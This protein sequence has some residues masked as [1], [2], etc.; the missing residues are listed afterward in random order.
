M[1]PEL[2]VMNYLERYLVLSPTFWELSILKKTFVQF[3]VKF[4]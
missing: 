1:E 2:F 4:L 3:K